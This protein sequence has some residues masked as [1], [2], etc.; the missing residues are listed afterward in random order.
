MV[1]FLEKNPQGVV[2]AVEFI[3]HTFLFLRAHFLKTDILTFSNHGLILLPHC[4]LQFGE[5]PIRDDG[6]AF[7]VNTILWEKAKHRI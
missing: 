3:Q 6:F 5:C 1:D 7:L 2:G 4:F